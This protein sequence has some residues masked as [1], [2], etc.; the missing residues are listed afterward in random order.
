MSSP[1]ILVPPGA[2][3]SEQNLL[4]FRIYLIYRTVLSVVFLLL[5][6]IPA[7][8]QLVG[9]QNPTLYIA[10]SSVFLFSNIALLGVVAARWQSS[11]ARLVLLFSVDIVCIT[12][13]SDSSGGM[14]S[15]LPLLLAIT[16]A[17][18]AVLI[19][20]RTVATL[21]AA[22]TVL[23]V[24]GDTLR[25]IS[26]TDAGV[27]ALFPAGLLGLLF[28]IVS[29]IVQ[30]V[31][32]RL[33]RVEALASERASDIYRLQRLNEQIVQN[34]QTGILLVDSQNRARVLNA[35]AGRLLDPSRPIALEQGRSL[36]DYSDALAERIEE[37]RR[38][39]RQVGSP[40]EAG[41]DGAE[42]VARFHSLEG[43]EEDQTLVFLEDYRPVAAYAQSLKLSS[44]GRLAASIAH[45]IR[46][47]LGAISHASQ[48]LNESPT[49]APDDK[50]MVDMVLTNSQRVNDIVES[51]LQ[52]SRREPPKL[53]TLKLVEW[54][55]G[56]SEHYHS[57]RDNPGKL[58]IEYVAPTACV[59]VDPE[60][61]QR[62]LD[63]LVDNAMRHSELAT[64]ECSA[65]LRIRVDRKKRECVIDVYDDGI[66]V[67]EADIPRLF[68]PFFTRSQGG[69]G[70]GLYLCRELCELNQARIAYLPTTEGRSRFQITIEHQE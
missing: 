58:N 68:E 47:P 24:L 18:S 49:L 44:L 28:F 3:G 45:E 35:A 59:L 55:S 27:T 6:T 29:G 50:R 31:A 64:G 19:S 26:T 51:V 1:A 39:G 16:V 53:E 32:L 14:S 8:R 13:L 36:T 9:A 52:I 42:L 57:A 61:L 34:M 23:A 11:N 46:N 41:G 40:F 5:I 62:V 69:S 33:G 25:L 2:M 70:L 21:V 17:S 43:G 4:L 15:G 67:S 30:L 60:H 38:S 56:Y 12:L 63:N 37:F 22:L 20:N 66:G 7:S 65:E 10:V 48:L 54:M